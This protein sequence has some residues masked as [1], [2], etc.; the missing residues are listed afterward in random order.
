MNV[1]DKDV[2][3]L[4]RQA[5]AP[6]PP[7]GLTGK[8][9]E[10]GRRAVRGAGGADEGKAR[11][12]DGP[13]GRR[14]AGWG[15]LV[16]A[17][18]AVGLAGGVVM[19]QGEMRTLRGELA[20]LRETLDGL[21]AIGV[22]RSAPPVLGRVFVPDEREEL[23]RL[24]ERVEALSDE[25]AALDR[26]EEENAALRAELASQRERL[27]PE[28]IEAIQQEERAWAIR[29]VNNL[30]RIGLAARVYATDND[31]QFPPNFQSI[32]HELVQTTAL[33]CPADKDRV[34][35][36]DWATLGPANI[37]YEMLSPGPGR[38]EVEP[39]RVFSRCPLHGNVGL[40]DGSVHMEVATRNPGALQWHNGV[41]YMV[42]DG[43]PSPP[44][45]GGAGQ[46]GAT[47]SPDPAGQPGR[48]GGAGGQA[49]GAAGA[50]FQMSPELMRRYGLVPAT[51][52]AEP[53]PAADEANPP[54][55]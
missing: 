45:F 19:Q 25:V 49:Q 31:D 16:P 44:G 32:S 11:G 9:E 34:P 40:C 8:L 41:L 39:S 6:P 43:W 27:A 20:T 28:D 37:S 53:E 3:R 54:Q 13:N 26:L 1:S 18:V 2:E 36:P 38:H 46:P 48:P 55:P 22:G 15:L 23:L 7:V 21:E 51:G 30:K 14:W 12:L 10:V 33:I 4:L 52:T 42:A 50:A 24:R 17:V 35:A 47:G 29:C 5:P